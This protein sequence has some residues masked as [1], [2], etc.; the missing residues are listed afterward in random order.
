MRRKDLSHDRQAAEAEQQEGDVR[1]GDGVEQLLEM[2][3]S[4]VTWSARLRYGSYG[5]DRSPFA[6]AT[7]TWRPSACA[8]RS[9]MLVGHEVDH[10]QL[11]GL[12]LVDG[13]G[14]AHGC[15]A[16]SALRPRSSA[17]PRM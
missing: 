11:D 14:V 3:G 13:H 5:R 9:S 17:M 16:Q 2:F 8:S 10:V 1:V 15:S 7:C 12:R 4:L 6:S